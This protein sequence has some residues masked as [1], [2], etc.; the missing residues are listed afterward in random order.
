MSHKAAY[1]QR[2]RNAEATQKRILKAAKR[3]FARHGLGGARV[4]E[5]AERADI[6]KRMIYHYF[7][8][9]K[10]LFQR[11]LEEAY[12]DIRNAEQKLQLGE[13][14]SREALERLV[15][16]T[17]DYYLKNPEFITLVNS[18]NL[19]KAAHLKRSKVIHEVSRRFVEMVDDLLKRGEKEGVFRSGIDPVQL[20]ITI[21]GIAYY[22][23][24]NRHTGSI[25]FERNLMDAAALDDRLQ[26]NIETILRLVCV[27]S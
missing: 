9:K 19:H 13:L 18:E 11:V 7:G 24:T 20:N 4:D 14:P 27:E 3:E 16:F 22:Y 12:V 5:I 2:T 17:W 25:V 26:F 23:L 15:R 21:A 10:E 1:P 6:N 8:S